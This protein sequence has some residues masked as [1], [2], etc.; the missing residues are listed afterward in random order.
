MKT[1]KSKMKRDAEGEPLPGGKSAWTH[2]ARIVVTYLQTADAQLAAKARTQVELLGRCSPVM[3]KDSRFFICGKCKF[4]VS[5]NND[6]SFRCYAKTDCGGRAM[7]KQ[8]A[9]TWQWVNKICDWCAKRCQGSPACDQY[10]C[11]GDSP[12]GGR[13]QCAACQKW[14]CFDHCRFCPDCGRRLCAEDVACLS[15]RPH[16]CPREARKKSKMNEEGRT[17]QYIP[18]GR[19]LA[20]YVGKVMGMQVKRYYADNERRAKRQREALK[21]AGPVVTDKVVTCMRCQFVVKRNDARLC[22][23]VHDHG[24]FCSEC[25]VDGWCKT[26]C[27]RQC[28]HTDCSAWIRMQTSSTGQCPLCKFHWCPDHRQYCPRCG[29]MHCLMP[30][31]PNPHDCLD[32]HV[33]SAADKQ[34]KWDKASFVK[35]TK[36]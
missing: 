10:V 18:G 22:A 33:C 34:V 9:S 1:G 13:T 12:N 7:C 29:V 2:V 6:V 27:V 17:D 36:K 19:R 26:N 32:K 25:H 16:R 31:Y 3:P 5:N 20:Q 30:G 24:Y 14:L 35:K 4:V 28:G 8:C 23:N 11:V 15:V 21:E